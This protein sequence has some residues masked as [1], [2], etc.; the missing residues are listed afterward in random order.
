[1]EVHCS[2]YRQSSADVLEY[3]RSIIA[4]LP[5]ARNCSTVTSEVEVLSVYDIGSAGSK[6]RPRVVSEGAMAKSLKEQN[7]GRLAAV[8]IGNLVIFGW[9]FFGVDLDFRKWHS[10]LPVP[11]AVGFLA[12]LNGLVDP[13][14]KARLVFWRWHN[15]LPGSRAFSELAKNDRRID[16]DKILRAEDEDLL[17]SPE[18][19]NLVWF[20]HYY[21]PIKNDPSVMS[22]HRDYLFTRDYASLSF[23]FLVLMSSLG[24][25]YSETWNT[26]LC[27]I[28]LMLGQYL[29]VRWAATKYGERLVTTVLA[30]A[31]IKEG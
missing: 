13:N 15:P 2:A 4:G 8:C 25:V 23:V 10:F 21:K 30:N 20:N 18:K 1:M 7:A 3:A 26:V 24:Y 27:Y 5:R 14:T 9:M 17:K 6:Y 12:V 29:A 22:N 28:I 19:Q 31:K 16:L 11:L